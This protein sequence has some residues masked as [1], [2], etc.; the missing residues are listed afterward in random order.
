MFASFDFEI[1]S[2]SNLN[3]LNSKKMRLRWKILPC[4]AKMFRKWVSLSGLREC[5]SCCA[6]WLGDFSELRNVSL[7]KKNIQDNRLSPVKNKLFWGIFSL[8]FQDKYLKTLIF[9]ALPTVDLWPNLC[10]ANV[11]LVHFRILHP[12]QT[13]AKMINWQEI[14]VVN[15]LQPVRVL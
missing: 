10:R 1:R 14:F 2:E 13:A 3:M 6:G 4:F 11:F 5:S 8:K 12:A 9:L 7:C 15:I